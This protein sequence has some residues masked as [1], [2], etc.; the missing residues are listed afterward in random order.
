MNK[1]WT[2]YD[3]HWFIITVGKWNQKK[4]WTFPDIKCCFQEEKWILPCYEAKMCFS[5]TRG[6]FILETADRQLWDMFCTALLH[7]FSRLMSSLRK[8]V[9]EQ[10]V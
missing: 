2:I 7:S 8:S 9:L 5:S 3:S 4:Q 1:T 6:K 10:S